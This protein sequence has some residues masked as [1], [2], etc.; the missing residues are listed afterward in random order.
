MRRLRLLRWLVPGVL[1]VFAGAA[2]W[3]RVVG[4]D[5]AV[6]HVDP[7]VTERT[8]RDNDVL[9]A[10]EGGAAAAID[11]ITKPRP[12]PPADLLFQF[13]AIASNAARTQVVA[14]SVD[15]GM[16]T[17]VQRSAVFGFPDYVTVKAIETE[18][19]SALIIWSRSRYGYSDMGVN[20]ERVES[21]LAQIGS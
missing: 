4:S 10:P 2:I 16:V 14:G 6:W 5:P 7:A 8:G 18:G 13:D 3:L 21:W 1:V 12:V 15:E 19:G 20:R 11:I 9:V 17:Y